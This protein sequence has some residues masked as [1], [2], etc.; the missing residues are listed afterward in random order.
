[1]RYWFFSSRERFLNTLYQSIYSDYIYLRM[2][3][4]PAQF[5]IYSPLKQQAS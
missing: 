3:C 2:A 1:M 4:L 5:P